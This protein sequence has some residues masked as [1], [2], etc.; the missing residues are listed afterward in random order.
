MAMTNAQSAAFESAAGFSI[1]VSSNTLLSLICGAVCVWCAWTLVVLYK[2]WQAGN[3]S[4]G[5]VG[6]AIFRMIF[7]LIVL[8]FV[9]LS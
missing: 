9:I 6:G 3:V 4:A 5:V 1:T 8:F 7:S 2:G